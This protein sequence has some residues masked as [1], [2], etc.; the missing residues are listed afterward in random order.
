MDAG[1]EDGVGV[2]TGAQVGVGDGLSAI[3]ILELLGI[4]GVRN[5]DHDSRFTIHDF[6]RSRDGFT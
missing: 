4:S 3:M 5:H 1:E 2:V 6:N